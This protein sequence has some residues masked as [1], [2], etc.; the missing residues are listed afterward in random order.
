MS[1]NLQRSS[2]EGFTLREKVWITLG[3]SNFSLSSSDPVHRSLNIGGENDHEC[4]HFSLP[5]IP[6]KG[7][8]PS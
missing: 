7:N 2:L 4:L 6:P 1:S 8:R 3:K 5:V